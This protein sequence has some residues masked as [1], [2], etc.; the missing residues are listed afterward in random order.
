MK[1]LSALFTVVLMLCLVVSVAF[2]GDMIKAATIKSVDQTTGSIVLVSDGKEHM[3]K[4]DSVV[5]IGKIKPGD[6]V[7]L[8]TDEGLHL[9][10]YNSGDKV[11]FEFIKGIL[12]S[13]KF[14]KARDK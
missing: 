13:I 6:V 12:K 10:Q 9:G 14:Q 8:K 1:K 5:D 7:Q 4:A 3:V 2:A 11:E